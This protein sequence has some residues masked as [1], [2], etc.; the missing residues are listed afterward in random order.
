MLANLISLIFRLEI[1]HDELINVVYLFCSDLRFSSQKICKNCTGANRYK[2]VDIREP[3]T[4]TAENFA[5]EKCKSQFAVLLFVYLCGRY[6]QII[7]TESQDFS[8]NFKFTV[9]V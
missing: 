5:P 6:W 3:S 2:V 7:L 1:P 4:N 9:H 8:S